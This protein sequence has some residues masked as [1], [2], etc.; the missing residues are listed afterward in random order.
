MDSWFDPKI[1]WSSDGLNRLDIHFD[2]T[3][4]EQIRVS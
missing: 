4:I 1:I 3:S 2:P